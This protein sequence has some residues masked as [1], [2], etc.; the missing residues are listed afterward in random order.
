MIT[1]NHPA[2][3]PAAPSV[4]VP[5]L[6]SFLWLI[7]AAYALH[8][9]EEFTGN[10]PGWVEHSVHGTFSYTGFILNNIAFMTVLLI[11]VTLNWRRTTPAR[12]TALVAWVSANL[13]WDAMFHLILTPVLDVYSPGLVTAALLYI[14]MSLL[15]AAAV[16]TQHVLTPRRFTLAVFGGLAVFGFVVWYGLFHFAI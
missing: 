8:I 14:P 4:Q 7:P 15:T 6:R 16:L 2:A 13:F 1:Q 10:F 9:I 5:A 12:A 11:V 3:T